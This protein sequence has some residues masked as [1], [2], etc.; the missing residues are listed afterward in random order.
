MR[1]TLHEVYTPS[2]LHDAHDKGIHV[3]VHVGVLI[4]S[5]LFLGLCSYEFPKSG[6]N[7]DTLFCP[8]VSPRLEMLVQMYMYV[9]VEYIKKNREKLAVISLLNKFR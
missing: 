6:H 7:R 2:A 8:V 3:H 4:L 5:Q 9:F 1:R